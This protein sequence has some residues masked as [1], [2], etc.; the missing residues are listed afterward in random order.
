ME[1]WHEWKNSTK[2]KEFELK[3][4]NYQE[5]PATYEEYVVSLQRA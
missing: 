3:L 4:A 5:E 1:N 2:R